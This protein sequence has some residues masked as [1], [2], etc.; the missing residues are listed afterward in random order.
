MSGGMAGRGSEGDGEL[1]G[2]H[3]RSRNAAGAARA[4]NALDVRLQVEPRGDVVLIVQL[5]DRLVIQLGCV[6]SDLRPAQV[7]AEVAV[8]PV[9]PEHVTVP[10]RHESR[11]EQAGV[12]E[13]LDRVQVCGGI[14]TARKPLSPWYA[15]P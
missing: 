13:V 11:V 9:E 14:L 5:E 12:H 7:G 8:E 2:Q 4:K 1:Q 10:P 3:E 6:V 15:A